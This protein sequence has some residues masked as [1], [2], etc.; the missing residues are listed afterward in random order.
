MKITLAKYGGFCFGVQRALD[1]VLELAEKDVEI[2]TYGP[3]I[4][5]P[6]VVDMLAEKGI[7]SVDSIGD[8]R[9]SHIVIRSHGASPDVY[10]E[11]KQHSITVVDATCPFVSKI[12]KKAKECREKSL[13]LIIV[14]EKSHPETIGINGWFGDEAGRGSSGGDLCCRFSHRGVQG[15]G[16]EYLHTYRKV[17]F[18]LPY[19]YYSYLFVL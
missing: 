4:H 3:I 7:Y 11:C 8:C 18:H 6:L 2:S 5:N 10:E 19:P 14:G 16:S 15:G 9:T 12:Q 13:E 17:C 1:Q